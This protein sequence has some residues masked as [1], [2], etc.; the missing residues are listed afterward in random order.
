LAALEDECPLIEGS[1]YP[2]RQNASLWAHALETLA[3]LGRHNG[4]RTITSGPQLSSID[5]PHLA[6]LDYATVIVTGAH[7]AN[8][9]DLSL[10]LYPAKD[11]VC[12]DI[13]LAGLRPNQAYQT[14]LP[15]LP[16]VHSDHHGRVKL[17]LRLIGRT[18][19]NLRP[20]S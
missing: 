6:E 19:I 4:L 13:G 2:H 11:R 1:D 14:G 9:T 12:S 5:G 17:N 10:T 8:R 3:R 16:S 20:I 15:E 7:R 18:V